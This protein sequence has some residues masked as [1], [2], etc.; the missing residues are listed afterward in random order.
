MQE[1]TTEEVKMTKAK[2]RSCRGLPRVDL[3]CSQCSLEASFIKVF[4]IP[5][6]APQ[7]LQSQ[8]LR[9]VSVAWGEAAAWPVRS[10]FPPTPRPCKLVPCK[11]ELSQV[12]VRVAVSVG[13]STK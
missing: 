8:I 5:R 9:K 10:R 2:D 3:V 6:K 4:H 13:D 12:R 11:S 1:L 7:Y